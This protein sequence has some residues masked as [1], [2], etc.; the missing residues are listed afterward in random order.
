M[1][2]CH[3]FLRQSEAAV[4]QA[5]KWKTHAFFVLWNTTTKM[6]PNCR[7][8]I[9]T[10]SAPTKCVTQY[11]HFAVNETYK[12]LVCSTTFDLSSFSF[13]NTMHLYYEWIVRIML[14]HSRIEHHSQRGSVTR[15]NS[16]HF[17]EKSKPK[18]HS[19]ILV[20]GEPALTPLEAR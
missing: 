15:E 10:C 20:D 18:S 2:Q 16:M 8:R 9:K 13:A 1:K 12:Q 4:D 3:H 19:Q 11:I 5:L 14:K 6:I 7:C 17:L